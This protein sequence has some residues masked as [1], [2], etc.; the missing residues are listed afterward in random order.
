L[1]TPGS[2]VLG[3][4]VAV[5]S[6]CLAR[7]SSLVEHWLFSPAWVAGLLVLPY[8]SSRVGGVQERGSGHVGRAGHTVGS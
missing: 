7:D 2:G 5:V 1:V 3:V 6:A 4:H 8:S